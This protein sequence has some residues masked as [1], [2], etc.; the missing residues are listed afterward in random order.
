MPSPQVL[1][2]RREIAALEACF[3]VIMMWGR[4]GVFF[5]GLATIFARRRES[6]EMETRRV[7]V[8]WTLP[9]SEYMYVID[10]MA[11][12]GLSSFS[13]SIDDHIH[14]LAVSVCSA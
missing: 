10:K 1:E 2:G 9:A 12:F 14:C 11:A 13:H 8:V 5:L 4:L 6:A 7:C 3:V